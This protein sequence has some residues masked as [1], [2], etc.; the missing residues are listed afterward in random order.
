VTGKWEFYLR[1]FVNALKIY[2]KYL[3]MANGQN[4]IKLSKPCLE[5]WLFCAFYK[6]TP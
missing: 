6:A 5:N 2:V 3:Q 1:L 4:E